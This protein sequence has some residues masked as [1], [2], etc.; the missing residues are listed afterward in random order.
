MQGMRRALTTGVSAATAALLSGTLVGVVV[1]LLLSRCC[2]RRAASCSSWKASGGRL[3]MRGLG[4]ALPHGSWC[5]TRTGGETEARRS[6]SVQRPLPPPPSRQTVRTVGQ[7]SRPTVPS[8]PWA[9]SFATPPHRERP[10]PEGRRCRRPGLPA[11]PGRAG[12]CRAVG[13]G[14]RLRWEGH[15]APGGRSWPS[16][17]PLLH[18]D[19][20]ESPERKKSSRTDVRN[21]RTAATRPQRGGREHWEEC[22]NQ[23][24]GAVRTQAG[25]P[26]QGR[27]LCP[28]MATHA[29]TARGPLATLQHKCPRHQSPL[30]RPAQPAAETR[31]RTVAQLWPLRTRRVCAGGAVTQ[32]PSHRPAPARVWPLATRTPQQ[33]AH[34]RCS[35]EGRTQTYP[36]F[37]VFQTRK[38][39]FKL[40]IQKGKENSY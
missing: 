40:K 23:A 31:I 19:L 35:G 11:T 17:R 18:T 8:L 14:A 15:G 28:R 16:D 33:A 12:S 29:G 4:R 9:A 13:T 20:S 32:T 2:R 34:T 7:R 1:L 21:K 5:A 26:L 36:E 10:V 3:R 6:P 30:Q 24:A 37:W 38:I 22:R 25:A 27:P 39:V